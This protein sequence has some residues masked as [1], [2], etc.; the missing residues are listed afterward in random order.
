MLFAER[1]QCAL[2]KDSRTK[3]ENCEND[4]IMLQTQGV[5]MEGGGGQPRASTLYWYQKSK[6]PPA[7]KTLSFIDRSY[8]EEM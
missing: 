2:L 7:F 8:L 1:R 5:G 3:V 6:V 4:E